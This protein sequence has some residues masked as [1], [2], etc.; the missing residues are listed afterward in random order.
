MTQC[1]AQI[2]IYLHINGKY[3]VTYVN[4]EHNVRLLRLKRKMTYLHKKVIGNNDR[5]GILISKTMASFVVEVGGHEH[6]LF[7]EQDCRNAVKT[8]RT[9]QLGEGDAEVIHAYFLH[10]S[11]NPE[12]R[13]VYA[14]CP[15]SR[16]PTEDRPL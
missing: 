1:Q 4:H 8:M 13:R 12:N 10:M 11:S 7:T 15:S 6:V 14:R 2:M 3:Q 16:A 5:A 9:L